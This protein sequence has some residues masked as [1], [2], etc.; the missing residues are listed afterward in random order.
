MTQTISNIKTGHNTE[1]IF[2]PDLAL[3]QA[4]QTLREFIDL[5][6]LYMFY[7]LRTLGFR[8]AVFRGDKNRTTTYFLTCLKSSNMLL[9]L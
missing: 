7:T 5:T 2:G 1:R 3:H 4:R 6:G 8:R 9:L